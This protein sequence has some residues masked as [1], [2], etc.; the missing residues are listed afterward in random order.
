M[1]HQHHPFAPGL[2]QV[3]AGQRANDLLVFVQHGVAAVAAF[4]HDLPHVVD[5]VVQMEGNQPLRGAGPCDGRGLIDQAVY[6]AGVQRRGDDAGLAGVF[7]PR[8][9][10]V[11]LAEDDAS[12]N[13][14]DEEIISNYFAK[15]NQMYDLKTAVG[16]EAYINH[17]KK[18]M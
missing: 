6:A 18:E 5:V 3:V 11:G 15:M 8:G 13:Q 14:M 12:R 2:Q 17:M 7:K 9:V 4:Q 16:V 1:I 10:D